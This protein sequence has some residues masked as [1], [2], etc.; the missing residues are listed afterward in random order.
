[1]RARVRRLRAKATKLWLHG[2]WLQLLRQHAAA[3]LTLTLTPNA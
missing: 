2:R 3:P 1:M